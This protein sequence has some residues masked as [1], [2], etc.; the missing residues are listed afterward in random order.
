MRSQN[1][2][3]SSLLE[4]ILARNG[5]SS[6]PDLAK[7]LEVSIPTVHRLLAA[8]DPAIV[9][10]GKAR[11]ARYAARRLLR[12][13]SSPIPLFEI[14][15]L[16]NS[17]RVSELALV[18]P[19]G[20]FMDLSG[21]GLP[22]PEGSRDGWWDG[23]PYPLADM[24]PQG[25]MG[26]QLA[27]L[28]H[29]ALSVS[30]DPREWSDDDV[31]VV[32]SKAGVDLS[33]SFILGEQAFERWLRRRE[34]PPAPTRESH[35]PSTYVE[36]AESALSS[37]IA[38]SSAA[39]EFP[40]FTALR[41]LPGAPTPHVLV[42]FSG[43]NN[44][45]AVP[46]WSD[47]L[48]CEHLALEAAANVADLECSRSRIICAGGRTFLESERFDRHGM[49]GRSRLV[50]L[51]VINGA[52]VGAST[53]DWTKIGARLEAAH[54][55]DREVAA[56]IEVIWWFGQLIAN[57]DMHLGNISFCVNESSRSFG[58]APV[59]DML[60]MMYAPLPGGELPTR[61]FAPPLPMPQHALAWGR[62]AAAATQFWRQAALDQRITPSFRDTCEANAKLLE[63]QVAL[64]A[65]ITP[66]AKVALSASAGR[67]CDACGNDPCVCTNEN[68]SHKA[69]RLG[70]A[71][72][73]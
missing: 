51:D 14:D 13:R 67:T 55:I 41:D 2:L 45:A 49:F 6:A 7:A 12:G 68:G 33:G 20:S 63:R 69:K 8:L 11:R 39:G 53:S 44:S 31:C 71:G 36:L 9:A 72:P 47:L 66:G 38:G 4:A 32:L 21:A 15:Q 18:R 1:V 50:S 30:S 34:E 43:A 62:A 25:Y 57:T 10:G 52:F 40:K 73:K 23:L 59:Y 60:P 27:Q 37:G 64:A 5:V 42:K 58:L 16:G 46:R 24:R 65:A 26:R 28:E 54:L 48:V 70:N 22:V 29:R 61:Q 17:R 35:L 3:Q 19:Q 56:Q